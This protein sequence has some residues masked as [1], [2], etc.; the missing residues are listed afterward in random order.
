MT[1]TTMLA[2]AIG[3]MLAGS[4]GAATPGPICQEECAPRI[5]RD[6]GSLHGKARRKCRRQL[7]RACKA[8]TPELA[9]SLTDAGTDG[10]PANG[11]P[12]FPGGSGGGA[13]QAIT[14]ALGNKLVT[15]DT[16]RFFDSG[17][18][19]ETQKLQLCSSGSVSLVDTTITSTT[20]PNFDNTF[21]DTKTF[22]GTWQVRLVGGA[23][24]LELDLGEP[25]PRQLAV[26][27]DAQGALFLD[28]TRADVEDAGGACGGTPAQPSDPGTQDPTGGTPD[29]VAQ[30]T[31]ALAG[32]AL[33]LTETN[34]GFGTRQ[35][36]IVL[37][38]S[39]R[40]VKD[41]TVSAAPGHVQETIG[42]WVVT[43]DGTGPVV[44]LTADRT[45]A[46]GQ[47]TVAA[48]AQG[49][50]LLNGIAVTEGDPSTVPGICAQL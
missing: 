34:A 47:F 13:V 44:T 41:V 21:D 20:D 8:T 22:D 3:A 37:C 35:T 19:A 11:G 32:H 7:V 25:Q 28:G 30:V 27:Q 15:L 49:N 2:V 50:L 43:V 23:P 10:G 42:A 5:Q 46:D 33:V 9:C 12:G 16:N 4:A 36:A 17:S 48:D 45:G 6:C 18:I 39:G 26:T 14:A 38:A 29:P 1:R 24:V 31:Q 40:Y